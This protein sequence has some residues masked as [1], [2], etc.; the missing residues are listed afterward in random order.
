MRKILKALLALLILLNMTMMGVSQ[1]K[2]AP[3]EVHMT[4]DYS[5][6]PGTSSLNGPAFGVSW[7][8]QNRFMNTFDFAVG[9]DH[10]NNYS[11]KKFVT[12]RYQFMYI[13]DNGLGKLK[14]GIGIGMDHNI[15]DD[16]KSLNLS[17]LGKIKYPFY[18]SYFVELIVPY[19]IYFTNYN[20]FVPTGGTETKFK[21]FKGLDLRTKRFS[22]VRVGVG[23]S[24]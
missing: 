23:I 7:L 21:T 16:S 14:T 10:F 19:S 12:F 6:R 9:K 4:F 11:S 15:G 2:Y 13:P 8:M 22:T 18:N 20:Q 3:K 17:M 1:I 5:S 24:F